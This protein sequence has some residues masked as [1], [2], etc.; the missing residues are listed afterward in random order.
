MLDVTEGVDLSYLQ[1]PLLKRNLPD[2]S[3]AALIPGSGI[4]NNGSGNGAEKE[5]EHPSR[6]REKATDKVTTVTGSEEEA[7]LNETWK[8]QSNDDGLAI[9]VGQ[10]KYKLEY[11]DGTAD[12]FVH[13]PTVRLRGVKAADDAATGAEPSTDTVAAAAAAPVGDE[14][15]IQSQQPAAPPTVQAAK[16]TSPSPPL[17][18]TAGTNNDSRPA[19]QTPSALSASSIQ[20]PQSASSVAPPPP[21]PQP[22]TLPHGTTTSARAFLEEFVNRERTVVSRDVNG[23]PTGRIQAW[24]PEMRK[25][26]CADWEGLLG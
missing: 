11:V 26:A 16:A 25:R 4:G 19:Q 7:D 13:G 1:Y 5:K 14:K 8:P 17:S 22:Q 23:N 18:T 21:P 15:E 6:D 20:P 2:T 3:L 24:E 12:W 9:R 10:G